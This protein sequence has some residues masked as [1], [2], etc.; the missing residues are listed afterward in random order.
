MMEKKDKIMLSV[1]LDTLGTII[2]GVGAGLLIAYDQIKK[3][4]YDFN[5]VPGV[6]CVVFGFGMFLTGVYFSKIAKNDNTPYMSDL[7]K[8]EDGYC[9]LYEV[10]RRKCSR[11]CRECTLSKISEGKK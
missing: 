9:K 8:T 7:Y 11:D 10:E 6:A 4:T 2:F 3:G 1:S 5:N